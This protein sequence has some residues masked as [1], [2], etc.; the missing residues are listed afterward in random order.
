MKKK[1][2][3][4]VIPP[5]YERTALLVIDV[6]HG[7]FQKSTP[8]YRAEQLLQNLNVLIERARARGVAV[9]YVQHSDPRNLVKGSPGWQLHPRLHPPDH[10]PVIHKLHGNAFE[11]TGLNDLLSEERVGRLVVTGLV[12]HGCVKA[13][14]LG[15]RELGYPVMLVSDAHSN[16]SSDAARLIEEWHDKLTQGGVELRSTEDVAFGEWS[17]AGVR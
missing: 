6:Q 1:T 8:I 7:L 5:E 12:T 10:E 14:C 2:I 17:P 9:I 15:G 16:Y 4:P 3:P 13:T 11:E